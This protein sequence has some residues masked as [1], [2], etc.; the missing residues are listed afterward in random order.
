MAIAFIERRSLCLYTKST[1]E[2]KMN[3]QSNFYSGLKVYPELDN[4]PLRKEHV[5]KTRPSYNKKVEA[6]INNQS[7]LKS[8]D[9][10]QVAH[11]DRL[12]NGVLLT[13]RG[14]SQ[15]ATYTVE[16]YVNGKIKSRDA[17]G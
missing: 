11:I 14:C 9:D 6:L 17:F 7:Q 5:C 2:K 1:P 12:G 4:A 3:S 13:K 16:Q 15:T 10:R 8:Q